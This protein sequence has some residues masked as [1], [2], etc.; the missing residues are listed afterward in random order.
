MTEGKKIRVE[1]ITPVY[2]RK[3]ITL[4]CLRSLAAIDKTG[5]DVH[6]IIVDDGSTDGTGAAIGKEFPDVELVKGD[7]TLHFT[8]GTN[9]GISAALKRSPDFILAIN[10]DSIFHDQFL[11]R[12]VDCAL[13]H[14]KS[15]VG[16]LLLLWD[17]PHKIFQV[18]ARWDTWFGG[19]R[20]PVNLTAFNVPKT[21]W[22]AEIIVGNC[23]LFPAEA[24]RQVGLMNEKAYP[25]GFGDSEYTPRMRKAGWKLLIV[26][27]SFVWCQP[28]ALTPSMNGLHLRELLRELFI[29]VRS[30]RNLWRMLQ[31]RWY[32][33]PS[34]FI[35]L[36]AFFITLARLALH[37]LGIGGSWPHWP[38][39]EL[40]RQ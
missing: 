40:A 1:I 7:G 17:E 8:R 30:K 35:G 19:W 34:H 4:Q 9:V 24:V 26:P 10:D 21:P 38:D 3:E 27:T 22:A 14:P 28:N 6:V 16:P 32:A 12:L 18:G 31:D 2:N 15:V 39:P 36:L 29:N 25:F 5:L 20:H 11:R 37:A 33:A 13:E 23:T